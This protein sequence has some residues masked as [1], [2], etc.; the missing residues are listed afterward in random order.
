MCKRLIFMPLPPL[1]PLPLPLPFC[2][3]NTSSYPILQIGI[4]QSLP[5]PYWLLNDYACYTCMMRHIIKQWGQCGVQIHYRSHYM[6]FIFLQKAT[7]ERVITMGRVRAMC[8]L[9]LKRCKP[10][11]FRD[12]PKRL[13]SRSRWLRW[14]T[15]DRR[16]DETK[17]VWEQFEIYL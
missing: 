6:N 8:E 10:R 14:R 11:H 2:S 15:R 13:H 12:S 4:G 9:W 1:P 5:H 16:D 7:L 17:P 3:S